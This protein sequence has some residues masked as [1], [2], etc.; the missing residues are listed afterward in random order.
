M[1]EDQSKQSSEIQMKRTES[2]AGVLDIQPPQLGVE[3]GGQ[4]V[5]EV[6]QED[7]DQIVQTQVVQ[8]DQQVVSKNGT[9]NGTHSQSNIHQSAIINEHVQEMLAKSVIQA[10]MPDEADEAKEEPQNPILDL[11]A[12]DYYP[13]EDWQVEN[14]EL[15]QPVIHPNTIQFHDC[16]GMDS[17]KKSNLW[18][19]DSQ[20]FVYA[21]SI[22]YHFYNFV[23]G[24]NEIFFSRDGGGI[25]SVAV[26]PSRKYYSVAE[27]GT[28]PN[29]YIYDLTHRLY[30]VL[31]KGTERSYSNSIF[32]KDGDKF[33][34]V[35]SSPDYQICI[36]DWK[37]QKI[38]LKAKAFSQEVYKVGFSE[39]N[40][41]QLATSG[42]GHIKFWKVAET[43]TGLKLKGE[44]AKF[45]QVELSDVYAFY[46]FPD[47]KV[48]SGTEYGRL[49]LWE[50]N[51]IKVV[52]GISEEEPCHKGAIESIFLYKDCI[53]SGGK[54]G[55]LRSWKLTELDQAEGDDQL[56]YFTQP[57]KSLEL[58]DD[59]ENA[60]IIQVVTDEHF[61]LI[62]DQGGRVWRVDWETGKKEI[63]YRNNSGPYLDLAPSPQLNAA[64]TVG[65]DGAITLWDYVKSE[66]TYKRKFAKKAT[67]IQWMPFT[68]TNKG[69]V[70]VVG[71]SNGIVRFL[72]LNQD[73]FV[74][75]NVQKVH[76]NPI[77]KI[78]V[79]SNTNYV[80]V[81]SNKGEI[82][83]LK[84]SD[85][86]IQDIQAYC[87]WE[88]KL[89]I[90]DF[91]FDKTGAKVMMAC[92]DGYLYQALVPGDVDNSENY[93][94]EFNATKYLVRMMES[95]KPK[96][97]D[98]DLQFLMKLKDDKMPDVEWDP[99]SIMNVVY[100]GDK[101]FCT[102]EGKYLG[103]CYIIDLNKDRPIEMIPV[104]KMQTFHLDYK[105]D[106]LTIGYK[107]GQW[108]IRHKTDFSK[109]INK[110]SHDMDYGRVRKVSLTFDRTG[111]LSVSD[112]GTFY[113]YKLDFQSFL[114]QL[115]GN[116]VSDFQYSEFTMGINS[117]TF[118]EEIAYEEAQDILDDTI[119]SI[120]QAKLLAEE[121][122][123]RNEA[124]KKKETVK[125]RILQLREQFSQV[126]Q[127]NQ[128]AEDASKLTEDELCVDPEY[129]QMLLDRVAED[130]EE[131]RLEL[132][133]DRTLAKMKAEK[134]KA[135]MIDELEI[136][137]FMVK[138]F[139]NQASVQTFK[140]KK[141][142]NFLI[143]Q[144]KE[145]YRLIEEERKNQEN[146]PQIENKTQEKIQVQSQVK[147]T[148]VDMKEEQQKATVQQL[149]PDQKV[150]QAKL[151]RERLRQEEER[152][153]KEQE[154]LE[155]SKPIELAKPENAPD[156]QEAIKQYGDYKLKS[157]PNYEV[158]DNQRMNVSKKRKHMYML[159]EFIYNTKLKFNQQLLNLKKRKGNLID[160][161]KKYNQQIKK[162]NEQLGK[163]EQLFQP[164][165]D[166]ELE[167]P[168]SFMEI[169]DEQINEF[170]SK[171]QQQQQK[172]D[173]QKRIAPAQISKPAEQNQIKT[174]KGIRVQQSTLE[175]EM[176]TIQDMVLN[177]E[178]QRMIEEM[179]EEINQFDKDVVKCQ[180]E[181]NV[182]ESDMLIAQMK[183]VTYYQELIILEDMEDFDNKLIK[184]VL[185]FKKEKQ[186]LE[187]QVEKILEN[188]ATLQKKEQQ[189]DKDLIEQ[190]KAW[191]ELVHPD[192]EQKRNKIHDYYRKKFKR[193]MLKR[194]KKQQEK[195]HSDSEENE[196][197]E[198]N[199]DDNDDDIVSDD[200]EEEKPDISPVEQ[201]P[202]VRD[203]IEKICGLEEQQ[204][205]FK[206]EKIQNE[207]QKSKLANKIA[208]NDIYLKRA[209]DD[210]TQ[211]QR[212]K[213]QRVNQL[214]VSFVLKLS[215]V[216]NLNDQ[217]Q[218]PVDLNKSILFTEYDFFKLCKRIV[219][220][221]HEQGK[222]TKQKAQKDKTKKM[223]EKEIKLKDLKIEDLNKKYE[224]K[225]M[226]KFGDIIDLKILDALEPTKA[227]L[228][229]R[230]QFNQEEKEA[231]RKVSRAK[232]ELS[233]VKQQ[234][235]EV[236]R[237]NTKIF[238]NITKLG[239]QQM[240]LSKKLTSGNKQLFKGDNKEKR[241]DMDSDRQ[242]LEDLVKFLGKEI[243]DLK[244][245]IGLYKKKGG[246]I[247]TSITQTNQNFV[248]R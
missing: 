121:D 245:E 29:V 17:N 239:K 163:Q 59:G 144:L 167:D 60:Q 151:E 14:Q 61:W 86:N 67:C 44:I 199:D 237:E 129:K 205:N 5:P 173:E 154:L 111:V 97:E 19:I 153:K 74:L 177:A 130:V 58:V 137:K 220:L 204:D 170:I 180:N 192:D 223:Q 139:R 79:S 42:M 248:Q 112:D 47:G 243:E 68:M 178:K 175:E 27:K 214:D 45:G 49:I 152:I 100:Y 99:A 63:V 125:S 122:N 172:K 142:S 116:E 50:G 231:Q 228:D 226:L 240:D 16:F 179:Q 150:P 21:S 155:K 7:D 165:I 73:N 20:T 102:A 242:S 234:L 36:W 105:D 247:Y 215:Q 30:R 187:Q 207:Q 96:K 106:V 26:H 101:V 191:K 156:I 10:P 66:Q 28:F 88:T 38:L 159:E 238:T 225:H 221:K 124:N 195:E 186:N 157:S 164:D 25:G 209:N 40:V 210:L 246:H 162:I 183:L 200:D 133:W 24:T 145:T 56:N 115:S 166:K 52:I 91:C 196:D 176:K 93:L 190:L 108:D 57:I 217:K 46:P 109:Q 161:I 202:K 138:G 103:C 98:L 33:A 132:E 119:Y 53:I 224:E 77:Q 41:N 83:F 95:Q 203:V 82:F 51:V 182:L 222:I 94:Q 189:N 197:D 65:D 244:N 110:Q 211:Y 229:M 69:R 171:L 188:L 72:L 146:Q 241:S 89:S 64:I 149:D 76:P 55:F 143:E 123:R 184:E 198:E 206:Q 174:R 11:I 117:G 43:F 127:K 185:D 1:E 84:Y 8:G 201:D 158:P 208:Q 216:Q 104:Q 78:I 107:N 3:Q 22:S 90:N 136:D 15:I 87:L 62:G 113:V 230:S 168:H 35:G 148:A 169:S 120:Q 34:T 131:T 236:K 6:D 140:V 48:L 232:E 141:L 213:L 114:M 128:T 2:Q 9:Q 227:V 147:I 4:Q 80:A 181:K 235:L 85:S 54:D 233:K 212:K 31:E 193:E 135:Y 75:L 32:S 18:L 219:E 23:Q 126:R 81:L 39:Y 70:V 194:L 160:K 218:L 13:P 71:Y 134:L 118:A 92:K 12:D 37:Q